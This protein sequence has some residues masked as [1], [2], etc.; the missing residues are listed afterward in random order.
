LETSIARAEHPAPEQ[1]SAARGGG[2]P[3]HRST[4]ATGPAEIIP[5]D[6][7]A[8]G[9][10]VNPTT[11]AIYALGNNRANAWELN[12]INGPAGPRFCPAVYGAIGDKYRELGGCDGSLGKAVS[13]EVIAVG[14]RGVRA[15][16]VRLP[17]GR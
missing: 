4:A 5:T 6:A 12:I 8:L 1:C 7:D 3:H 11:H 13:P 14:G 2:L 10:A 15:Q 16:P 17:H 9:I